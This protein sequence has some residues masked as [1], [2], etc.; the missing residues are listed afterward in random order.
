MTVEVGFSAKLDAF[1]REVGHIPGITKREVDAAVK[2]A[3]AS[4]RRMPQEAARAARATAQRM[5]SITSS[6]SSISPAAGAATAAIQQMAAALGPQ[7]AAAAGPIGLAVAGVAALGS[8]GA[9][10]ASRM[11]HLVDETQAM[12]ETVAL[13][14]P[15]YLAVRRAITQSGQSAEKANAAL[16]KFA[17]T[18]GGRD[19]T[20]GEVQATLARVVAEI[21]A[22]ESPAERAAMRMEV[23]G[24]RSAAAIA[25]LTSG[26]LESAAAATESLADAYGRAEG[27]SRD[28]DRMTAELSQG[29]EEFTVRAGTVWGET[30]VALYDNLGLATKAT[31]EATGS[32]WDYIPAVVL[33]KT[34]LGDTEPLDRWVGWITGAT[35]ATDAA[36]ASIREMERQLGIMRMTAEDAPAAGLG[37]GDLG[38][39]TKAQREAEAA[40]RAARAAH[41]RAAAEAARR[42]AEEERRVQQHLDA[43]EGMRR[44]ILSAEAAAAE[45]LRAVDLRAELELHRLHDWLEQVGATP[46][47]V[48][49]AEAR[50]VQIEEAAAQQRIDIRQREA[51][52]IARI[53]AE[54]QRQQMAALAAEEDE[55][56]KL[57]EARRRAAEAAIYG[58]S[59][60]AEAV[61]S[62]QVVI[63]AAQ[64]AEGVGYQI[65]AA[66]RA[67]AEGGPLLG[68][69]LAG[70]IIGATA[71][72]VARLA[73]AARSS[74]PSVSV[75]RGRGGSETP[76][77][78]GSY[79]GEQPGAVFEFRAQLF[80]AATQDA[81]RRPGSPLRKTQVGRR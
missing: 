70:Q 33:A 65:T 31:K 61:T 43:M 60:I 3:G 29:W 36:T 15:Q 41:E 52:E 9:L 22:I 69:I 16:T 11:S 66:L 28:W 21:E 74:S 1:R 30:I 19:L 76:S 25:A 10:A 42:A 32:L 79:R 4:W 48:A 40:A 50:R 64:L 57:A 26:G 58:A 38:V 13:S 77:L 47:A 2:A 6:I 68:P 55:Q 78:P 62:N 72:L 18:L 44:A 20:S 37:L 8:A 81:Q 35:A 73:S 67:V 24:T 75:G 12:S 17:A 23:F 34:A 53:E 27:A 5:Q 71:P 49:L 54:A 59:A 14:V 7:M 46:D 63:A 39:Q 51:D 45:P 80:D 56:R